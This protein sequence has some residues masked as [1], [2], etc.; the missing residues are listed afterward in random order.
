MKTKLITNIL[1]EEYNKNQKYSLPK[2]LNEAF[3][4]YG[5]S[6]LFAFVNSSVFSSMIEGSG[7]DM[8][9]YLFNK[10]TK[11]QSKEMSRIDDLI[12]AYGFAKL[13]SLNEKNVLKAHAILSKNLEIAPKYKG[14][15][16]DKNVRIGNSIKTIYQ[17]TPANHLKQELNKFFT[18]LSILLNRQKYSYNEAFYYG[19][20]IHLVFENIH[21][22]ADGNG[23]MGRLI[24]KWFL[25]KVLNE[26][27]WNIPSEIN[28]WVKR[29]NYYKNLNAIG[30]HYENVNYK[31]ALPFL[32]M[33][34]ASFSLS[35]RYTK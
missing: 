12:S 20:M 4:K 34:P 17:A 26:K 31:H 6:K 24:E 19:S 33:L 9:N 13:N 3:K 35:K 30:D 23:R 29:E 11:F 14:C 28:Y 7:I 10:E 21:P 15:F 22:F 16:R 1:L 18:D 5:D 25:S 8:E 2:H 27:V 32:L